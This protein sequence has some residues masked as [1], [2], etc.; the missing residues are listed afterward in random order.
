MKNLK[1][2]CLSAMAAFALFAVPMC[3]SNAVSVN[4]TADDGVST[5]MTSVVE[6]SDET[7]PRAWIVNMSLN[8]YADSTSVRAEAKNDFT[9]PLSTVYTVVWLYS[10]ATYTENVAQ[11][12]LE[13]QNS[14]ADLDTGKSISATASIGGLER[15]WRARLM[16]QADNGS[17]NYKETD[18]F[19]ISANWT[20]LS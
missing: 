13:A 20:V 6:Q 4:A 5:G 1:K 14:I 8:L 17:L 16:Y 15:Y 12:T 11:M 18:T 2:I 7:S 3:A 10:S 9:F 19:H